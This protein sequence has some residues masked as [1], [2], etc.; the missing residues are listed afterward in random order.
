VARP[1]R[2]GHR[3]YR[4]TCELSQN[5]PYPLSCLGHALALA[6]EKAEALRI[7]GRLVESAISEPEIARVYL[8]LRDAGEALRWLELAAARRSLY[9]LRVSGDRRFDWL[10]PQARFQDVL[11]G[12][13]LPVARATAGAPRTIRPS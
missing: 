5:A 2:S 11:R 7:L 4:R 10:L 8:G 12:M 1:S 6:G 13:G 9:L 3:G